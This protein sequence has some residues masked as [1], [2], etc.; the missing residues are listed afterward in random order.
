[1]GSLL[2]ASHPLAHARRVPAAARARR[3]AALALLGAL[4]GPTCGSRAEEHFQLRVDE[5][6]AA[7]SRV[8]LPLIEVKGHAGAAGGRGHDVV[9]VLDLSDSTLQDSGVDLDGDGPGGRTD[10]AFL[11]RLAA[12]PDVGPGLVKR[13]REELDFEDTVLA[14]ELDAAEALIQRLDPRRFRVGLVVFSDDARVVAPVG[15]SPARLAESLRDVREG[16]YHEL[17]GTHF[18]AAID[19]AHAALVPDL[20]HP[21]LDRELAIVFLSDGAPTLPVHDDR[22]TRD[23]VEAA[24]AAGLAGIRLYAFAL[25]REGQEALGVMREMASLTGGRVEPIERPAEIVTALAGLSLAD[26]AGLRIENATTGSDARAL[27]TFPDG[28]FDAFVALAPGPNRIRFAAR[29]EDG[30]VATAWR[31]VELTAGVAD[32]EAARARTLLEELKRRTAEMRLQAEMERRRRVPKKVLEI[33]PEAPSPG[34]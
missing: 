25:G 19:A 10:P 21:P 3:I 16:F 34:E 2:R 26:L 1:M 31:E 30:A 28:S 33:E 22:A 15:S 13:L 18:A 23:A 4:L 20:A 9:I 29:S 17:H 6:A 32:A 5:P 7:Q 11:A 8:R 27:R 24:A 14:A 12:R